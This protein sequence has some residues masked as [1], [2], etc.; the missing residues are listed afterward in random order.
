MDGS[1]LASPRADEEP[2]MDGSVHEEE[3]QAAGQEGEEPEGSHQEEEELKEGDGEGSP[4]SA[5][6]ARK[7]TKK[8]T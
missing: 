7:V 6:L 3:D 5:K 2:Q 1:A 8:Q 4:V